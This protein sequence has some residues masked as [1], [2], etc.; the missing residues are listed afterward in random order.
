MVELCR[1]ELPAG[2]GV[3]RS[4]DAENELLHELPG[5]ERPLA[6]QRILHDAPII[7]LFGEKSIS[8]RNNEDFF[9]GKLKIGGLLGK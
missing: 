5:V 1:R 6:V 9:D 7:P 4:V 2:L 3:F 8:G